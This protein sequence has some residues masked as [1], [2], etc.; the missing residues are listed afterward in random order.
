[1]KRRHGPLSYR[2][3]RRPWRMRSMREEI[4]V[5]NLISTQ[6]EAIGRSRGGVMVAGGRCTLCFQCFLLLGLSSSSLTIF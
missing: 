3:R 2:T 1:M 5:A 4:A 6:A